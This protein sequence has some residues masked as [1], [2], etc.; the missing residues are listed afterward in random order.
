MGKYKILKKGLF[1]SQSKFEEKINSMAVQGWKAISISHQ[2]G[3]LVV[4]L[5]KV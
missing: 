1:E 4:M 2:G 5:E 3:Q